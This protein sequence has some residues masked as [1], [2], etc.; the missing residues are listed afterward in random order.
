MSKSSGGTLSQ[1]LV[2]GRDDLEGRLAGRAAVPDV[3]D[4]RQPRQPGRLALGVDRPVLGAALH[5]EDVLAGPAA[6][7]AVVL[8]AASRRCPSTR[9][10]GRR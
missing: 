2:E 9:R 8:D 10:R 3:A 5:V 7:D 4:P 1:E 6:L